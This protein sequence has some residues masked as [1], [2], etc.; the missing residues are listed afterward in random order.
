MARIA[1]YD[2]TLRDGTQAEDVAFTLDDK[3]RI[4][5]ELDD[6]GISYVEGGW[7]GSNPRDEEFFARVRKLKLKQARV[8]AFGSTRRA[9]VAAAVD[10]NLRQLL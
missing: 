7:P 10:L 5:A 1:I 2:T 4:A 9:N 3:L 6:C 8:A